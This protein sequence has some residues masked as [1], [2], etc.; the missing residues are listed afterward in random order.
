ME[1]IS[2]F[3]NR[4]YMLLLTAGIFAVVGFSMFLTTTTWYVVR[5]LES[6]EMLGVVLIAATVPRLLMITFGG[7]IADKYKKTTIMFSTN[8]IQSVLLLLLYLFVVTDNMTMIVLIILSAGFGMLDAFFGPASTSMV[9]KAVHKSQLQQANAYF[10]GVDQVSFII[11]PILA[12]IIMETIGVSTSYLVAT[13]LVLVSAIFVFPPLIKEAEVKRAE[14]QSPLADLL[15]GFKYV[16]SSNFLIIGILI[17][18]TLNFFVFGVLHIA[19]PVLV[20]VHGGSPINLSY[21]EVSLGVGLATGTFVLGYKKITKKG[22]TSLIGLFSALLFFIVFSLAPNLT[23]LTSLLFLVGFSMSFVFIPIFTAVQETTEMHL[24]GRVMS[25]IFLAMN[26]F[27]PIAYGLISSFVSSGFNIQHI[28]L[29]S[30]IIGIVVA[31]ILF[32][33]GREF[34]AI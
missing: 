1:Q 10:Q 15:D 30:G 24:M 22:F 14:K 13:I 20:D 19:I 4:T 7:V 8:L 6:P 12:G 5:E 32:V 26:G 11:G 17:L 2:L 3:K 25:L 29:G 27:D 33:K 18:I 28:L 9:P 31:V 34:K 21:M 23:V 16:Q